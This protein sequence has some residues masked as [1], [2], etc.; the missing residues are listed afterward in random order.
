[1]YGDV[2]Q[3]GKKAGW[4]VKIDLL[5][6]AVP[7]ID[8]ALLFITKRD[9]PEPAVRETYGNRMGAVSEGAHSDA[10]GSSSALTGKETSRPEVTDTDGGLTAVGW[11]RCQ[12]GIQGQLCHLFNVRQHIVPGSH[13]KRQKNQEGK[14]SESFQGGHIPHIYT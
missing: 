8:R 10:D 11:G 1:L 2:Q 7:G 12:R 6:E 9:S 3:G 4:C 13:Q 14:Q 5:S